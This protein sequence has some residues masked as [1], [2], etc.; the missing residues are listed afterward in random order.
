VSRSVVFLSLL[1][2]GCAVSSPHFELNGPV[3]PPSD[4][5]AFAAALFQTTDARLVGGHRWRLEDSGKVFDGIV[6]AIGRAEHS[7]NFESYIW[8]SGEPSNQILAALQKRTRGVACRVVVDPLGSP[9]FDKNVRPQLEAMGCESRIFRPV[10]KHPVAERDH[11]KIVVIDGRVGFVGGFGVRKEWVKAS[12]SRDPE[13]RDINLRIEGPVVN[14]LQR[15]FAQN[16][17][18][19]GGALLPAADF[20]SLSGDGEARAAFVG[21]TYSY[22]TDARRLVLLAVAAAKKRLWIWNAY[23]VPDDVLRDL[24]VRKRREGVDVRL[25]VPGDKN[26]VTAS[27]IG[28][29]NSY[30]PLLAAGIRIFEYQPSMMHAKVMILDDRVSLVGSINLDALSLQ[31]LEED[32]LV[33]DDPA[34]VEALERDWERDV[35]HCREVH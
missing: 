25:L 4:R 9:D 15:A 3:P 11:R 28:Q 12:G 17:Q 23:F 5:D 34:L 19:A 21:S 27:K 30:G 32:S 16:W 1:A 2:A 6:D 7:I 14:E 31:R 33:V 8:H 13:W 22:V 29:R 24:L 35:A 10:G 18:E 26:D 20:P